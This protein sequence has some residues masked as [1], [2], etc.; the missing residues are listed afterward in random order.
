MAKKKNI[1][2]STLP[3]PNRENR[4][5]VDIKKANNGY[6]VSSW[7]NISERNIM[8]ISKTKKE[9]LKYANRILNSNKR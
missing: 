4:V 1:E 6:V 3:K 5:S 2:N 9:A 8:Y 7:S